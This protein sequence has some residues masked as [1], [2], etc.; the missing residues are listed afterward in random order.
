VLAKALRGED[1]EHPGE[2]YYRI[3]L[4]ARERQP[5]AIKRQLIEQVERISRE[6]FPEARVTGDFILMTHLI[7]SMLGDQWLAFGLATVGIWL[8]SLVALQNFRLSLIAMVPNQ[9]PITMV[10]GLMGW[11][12]VKINMGAAMIAAVSLGLSVD[13]SIHYLLDFARMR[14]EGYTLHDALH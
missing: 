7:D 6:E 9:L 4:R 12:G 11:L 10:M 2:H 3:M 8:M 14:R 1:P 13:A 5:S